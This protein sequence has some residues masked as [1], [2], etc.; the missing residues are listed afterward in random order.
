MKIVSKPKR[1]RAKTFANGRSTAVRIPQEFGLK[2]GD[3]IDI[4]QIGGKIVIT[5]KSN[6]WEKIRATFDGSIDFEI[7][8]LGPETLEKREDF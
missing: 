2:V 3:N 7:E 6:G 1:K 4:E 8:K 5:P